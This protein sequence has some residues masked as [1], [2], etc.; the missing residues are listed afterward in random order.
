MNSYSEVKE[1]MM[2]TSERPLAIIFGADQCPNLKQTP[3][4]TTFLHQET[5]IQYGTEKFAR[6]NNMPVIYG[7]IHRKKRGHYEVAYTLL[8]ET[9][10]ELPVGE[11]TKAHTQCLEDDIRTEPEFWLWTHKR[12][13]RTKIEFE[14]R[15][16]QLVT[17]KFP[18]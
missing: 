10:S 2:K 14:Q 12:W 13:K 18:G 4:W 17:E 15:Q 7:F 8:C 9:P 11:I 16:G 3:Y 1:I 5:A 6:D